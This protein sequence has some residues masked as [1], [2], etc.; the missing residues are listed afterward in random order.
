MYK[1]QSLR[2]FLRGAFPHFSQNPDALHVFINTGEIETMPAPSL[3]FFYVYDLQI[4]CERW[5]GDVDALFVA[6]QMWA[7][8]HEP[9][10]FYPHAKRRIQFEVEH[11]DHNT[12]HILIKIPVKEALIANKIATEGA[13]QKIE[14][15]P[16]KEPELIEHWEVWLKDRK[17]WEFDY[18]PDHL[19]T[20][21]TRFIRKS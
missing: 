6:V 7:R 1:A 3:S 21:M 11:L 9:A 14:I 20:D 13:V 2:S 8:H 10:L 18:H 16:H 12:A 5:S 19:L 17:L 15:T 4:L